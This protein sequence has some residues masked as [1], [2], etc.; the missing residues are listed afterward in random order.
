MLTIGISFLVIAGSALLINFSKRR[1][2]KSP[3]G[4]TGMCHRTG[5]AVCGK[6]SEREH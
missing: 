1:Q 4:L 5:G 6:C 3:H 2:R